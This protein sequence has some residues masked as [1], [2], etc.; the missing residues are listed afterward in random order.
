[1][2]K[3]IFG[4]VEP[5]FHARKIGTRSTC[6]KVQFLLQVLASSKTSE[7][8]A[9]LGGCWQNGSLQWGLLLLIPSTLR[10]ETGPAGVS[11][12]EQNFHTA[13]GMGEERE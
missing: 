7:W 10:E 8:E 1:M 4:L 12:G 11:S 3:N 6:R 13:T 5:A 9:D 2:G